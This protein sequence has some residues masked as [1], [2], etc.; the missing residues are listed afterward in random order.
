M[1]TPTQLTLL[2]DSLRLA[3]E[4]SREAGH[5]LLK[6]VNS[7]RE[8]NAEEAHDVK[9]R[10]DVETEQMIRQKLR[11]HSHFPILGEEAGGDSS[12]VEQDK[13]FW[14]IDPLDGTYNYL[15]RLPLCCVSI[16][17]Y[18]GSQPVLGA[19]YDFYREEL[20]SALAKKSPLLF[21]RRPCQPQPVHQIQKAVLATGLPS[22]GDYSDDYLSSFVRQMQRFKKVRMIG[23]AA[24]ALAYVA[25]GRMDVYHETGIRLWDIAAGLA[26][27]S[28]AGG[29]IH[30]Q[31]DNKQELSYH[32]WVANSPQLLSA[33][34]KEFL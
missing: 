31:N 1:T 32:V 14:I 15:R 26:L 9:L 24:L 10:A 34:Q 22:E 16:G 5:Q 11:D 12:L 23:T 20:F 21:N 33:I 4:T 7:H 18:R 17:L 19:I 13:L 30:I 28:A 29:A 3:E 6:E 27:V 2:Q 25:V 8:I